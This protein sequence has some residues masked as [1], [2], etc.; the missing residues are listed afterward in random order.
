LDRQTA[1][2]SELVLISETNTRFTTSNTA[3]D[4]QTLTGTLTILSP[5]YGDDGT[6]NCYTDNTINSIVYARNAN[7]TLLIYQNPTVKMGQTEIASDPNKNVELSCT[8]SAKPA[9]SSL[10]WYYGSDKITNQPT[11]V[12][13]EY[14]RTSSY[15]FQV[16]ST[17]EG[18]YRCVGGNTYDGKAASGE[19]HTYVRLYRPIAITTAST[20]GGASTVNE[21]TTLTFTCS[22]LGVPQAADVQW[23][24]TR[25]LT[26]TEAVDD[27]HS[28]E[29]IVDYERSDLNIQTV[30]E[31]RIPTV[32]FTDIGIFKCQTSQT[33]D[34]EE[35]AKDKSWE[36]VVNFSAKLRSGGD[37]STNIFQDMQIL[38]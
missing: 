37:G 32:T 35:T 30:S 10:E 24:F 15:S 17:N 7:S 28:I 23:S 1:T 3:V 5:E 25:A 29:N 21:F 27:N 19:A 14:D 11:S 18:K 16:S 31:Y 22:T 38:T 8:V 6:Y 34:G 36:I 20:P 33:W 4:L 2:D 12:L 26:N 13:N 9:P